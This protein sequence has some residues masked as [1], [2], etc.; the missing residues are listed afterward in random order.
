MS[1]TRRRAA[2]GGAV[3]ILTLG[4]CS[5][6]FDRHEE[7]CRGEARTIIHDFDL[8][9]EYLKV[10]QQTYSNRAKQFPDTA[11]V[12]AEYAP[13]FQQKYGSDL[14]DTPATRNGAVVREDLFIMK[15]GKR[16]A[17]FVNF[18]ARQ[19]SGGRT[20]VACLGSFPELYETPI[21]PADKESDDRSDGS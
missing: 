20:I 4:G 10:A 18:Y 5:D 17:Q 3:L 12:V 13:G 2:T 6:V 9:N 21:S 8:W 16:V 1:F 19:D 14:S 15:D 11:R 7:L